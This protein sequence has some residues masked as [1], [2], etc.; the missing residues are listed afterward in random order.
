MTQ[1]G[2]G[3]RYL[4]DSLLP[5]PDYSNATG[6]LQPE[7]RPTRTS[8]QG[9]FSTTTFAG[10]VKDG[11]HRITE[12]SDGNKGK[13]FLTPGERNIILL[14]CLIAHGCELMFRSLPSVGSAR[15]HIL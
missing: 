6:E 10:A 8:E 12:K 14:A 13:N 1:E 11:A 9:C 2:A 7:S 4:R 5:V 15:D 3:R